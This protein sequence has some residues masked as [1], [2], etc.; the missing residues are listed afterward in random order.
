MGPR[1]PRC[2]PNQKILAAPRNLRSAGEG[3]SFSP[4]F[5]LLGVL[6]EPACYLYRQ[7]QPPAPNASR[8]RKPA[9]TVQL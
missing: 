5:L 3:A 7:Q 6:L 1:P 4:G 8:G 9:G 2:D